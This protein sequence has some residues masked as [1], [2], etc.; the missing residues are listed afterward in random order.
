MFLILSCTVLARLGT[1]RTGSDWI[2]LRILR[3]RQWWA[4]IDLIEQIIANIIMFIPLGFLL[5]PS[6]GRR[7]ILFG[8]IL[9][10]IVEISQL[11]FHCGFSEIDDIIHN[12]IGTWIGTEAY[13]YLCRLKSKKG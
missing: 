1:E 2:P 4:Q 7:S 11:V 5:T 6:Y 12:A 9:S 8:L 3:I 10:L 13:Y